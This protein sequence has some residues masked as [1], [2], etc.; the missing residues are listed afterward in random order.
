MGN[1]YRAAAFTMTALMGAVALPAQGWASDYFEGKT[2]DV[3]IPFA[4][5]GATD[6]F[7]RLVVEHLGRNVPGQPT[8]LAINQPG[9]G[10]LLGANEYDQGTDRDGLTLLATAS[11]VV[12]RML[13]GIEG[14]Q[15]QL[16]S[17]RPLVTAPMGQVTYISTDLGIEDPA[18]ILDASGLR[19][20]LGDAVGRLDNILSLDLLGVDYRMIPGFS[21][22]STTRMAFE[23]GETTIDAQFTPVYL[24]SSVPLVE[25]GTAMPLY[26]LDFFD[27]DGNPMRDPALPDMTTTSELY[28]Q[29]HGEDPSGPVWEAYQMVLNVAQTARTAVWVHRDAPPEA[30]AALEEGIANMATD[31]AFLA[32]AETLLGGYDVSY[33]DDLQ[34]VTR[35]LD[36]MSPETLDWIRNMLSERYEVT[37]EQ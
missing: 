20:G 2:I 35:V 34:V 19:I 30:I 18:D 16:D 14:A 11:P 24:Q 3:V 37:F 7:A 10:G 15:L 36:E 25:E 22:G 33:G 8:V 12:L 26:A 27:A 9:A 6:L 17:L 5:G 31:P 4:P 13:M 28:A 23:T 1:Q 21:G 29:L 32:N